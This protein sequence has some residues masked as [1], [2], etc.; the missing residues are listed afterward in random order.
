M[1]LESRESSATANGISRIP[2]DLD[3]DRSS[4]E[5]DHLA[6]SNKK[7]R[8]TIVTMGGEM[9]TDEKGVELSA[10]LHIPLKLMLLRIQG[11]GMKPRK[12]YY[13]LKKLSQEGYEK[14]CL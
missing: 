6:R 13:R 12:F 11:K 8:A 7:V 5:E 14:M 9:V 1:V 4:K 10:L 3:P 2:S